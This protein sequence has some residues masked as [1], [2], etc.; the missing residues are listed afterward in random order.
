VAHFLIFPALS[1]LNSIYADTTLNKNLFINS[2][3]S[4][5]QNRLK[6]PF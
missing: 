3:A 6:H 1:L 2:D 5:I 4:L